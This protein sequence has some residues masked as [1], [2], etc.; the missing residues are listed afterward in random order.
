MKDAQKI[1]ALVVIVGFAV[2]T[3]I[4]FATDMMADF[5]GEIA[6]AWI[7][8][9]GTVI[10]YWFGSSKGSSDKNALLKKTVE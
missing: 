8:N 6:M 2:I 4:A 3:I 9:F 7:V 10:G 1:L 5:R